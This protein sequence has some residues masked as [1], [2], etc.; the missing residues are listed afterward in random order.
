MITHF[1]T[2][3]FAVLTKLGPLKNLTPTL[4]VVVVIFTCC[5]AAD[6][7]MVVQCLHLLNTLNTIKPKC[8]VQVALGCTIY[9]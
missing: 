1:S 6:V 5:N 4:I 3:L 8:M 7:V 2:N 9:K